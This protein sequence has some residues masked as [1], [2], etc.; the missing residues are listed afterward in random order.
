MLITVDIGNSSIG[1]GYFVPS[2]L[3]TQRL[4]TLPLLNAQAYAGALAGFS[5]Q[6]HIEKKDVRCI[7]SSV[8]PGHTGVLQE[9][10][11]LFAGK[12]IGPLTVTHKVET[13]LCL[14]ISA[15]QTLGADR[16]TNASGAF[17]LYQKAVAV[18]DFGT[19]TTITMVDEKANLIG[20]AIMPGLRLMSA[21]LGTMTSL[22]GEVPPEK[23]D[24][25]LGRDTEAAIRSGLF[26]GTAGAVERIIAE[27][28][29]ET[30][31]H[32]ITVITGGHCLAMQQYMTGPC[33]KRSDLIHEGLRIIYEKNRP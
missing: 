20:G 30:G 3:V 9:A 7:I 16:L 19:A 26:Y 6:N 24:S 17:A 25:A 23:P 13:G 4:D 27:V 10:V 29:G 2:G 1:I 11:D 32:F 33:E 18:V 14:K 15:P 5:D 22:L 21:A 28:E 8:V 12:A 31:A